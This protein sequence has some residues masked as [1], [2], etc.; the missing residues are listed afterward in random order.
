MQISGIVVF[1]DVEG[2]VWGIVGDDGVRYQVMNKLP[3]AVKEPGLHIEAEIEPSDAV[4]I[5][6]WGR[7]VRVTGA[8]SD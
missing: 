1:E 2:G 6:Q 4:T 8:K 5:F 7:P 3:E